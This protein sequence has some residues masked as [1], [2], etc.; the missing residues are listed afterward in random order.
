MFASTLV[1]LLRTLRPDA[2]REAAEQWL[3]DGAQPFAGR[4]VINGEASAR[5]AGLGAIVDR[6]RARMIAATP[7]TD[8]PPQNTDT[9]IDS[10]SSTIDTP[11]SGVI[12][13]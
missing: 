11:S 3:R 2:S 9:T 6:A 1:A 8:N 5:A 13:T 12:Y 4:P 7:T 10:P